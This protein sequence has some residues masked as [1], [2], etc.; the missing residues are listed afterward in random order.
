VRTGKHP[1]CFFLGIVQLERTLP[2]GVPG[3]S[4][5]AQRRTAS[6]CGLEAVMEQRLERGRSFSKECVM[7]DRHS[8]R[9]GKANG[10]DLRAWLVIGAI[11]VVTMLA[12]WI[13]LLFIAMHS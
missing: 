3:G 9:R 11:F 10:Q 8:D 7:F 6:T 4:N 5:G 1:N 12:V 13:P 2:R